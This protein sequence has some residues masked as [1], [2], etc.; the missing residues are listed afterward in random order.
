LLDQAFLFI[1]TRTSVD[2]L[3]IQEEAEQQEKQEKPFLTMIVDEPVLESA[4]SFG[5]VN[6]KRSVVF[7]ALLRKKQ[8]ITMQEQ[9]Q[10]GEGYSINRKEEQGGFRVWICKRE[11]K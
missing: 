11:E 5:Y 1:R 6:P 9:D 10:V 4:H 7:L 8:S 3:S 2:H